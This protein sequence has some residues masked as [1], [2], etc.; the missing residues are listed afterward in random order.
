MTS[1]ATGDGDGWITLAD[2]THRW[3]RY[4]AAGL[5]LHAPA[6]DGGRCVLLQHRAAWSH[7][8]DTWGLPGGAADSGEGPVAAALREFGEEVAGDLG[9]VEVTG[10]Y[11]AGDR[12]WHYDSVLA[13]APEAAEFAPGN[14]E[15]EAVRWV[16]LDEVPSLPLLPAFA[17]AWPLLRS[18]L[19]ARLVLVVEAG[20]VLEQAGEAATPERT[21]ALRDALSGL[22]RGGLPAGDLPP[23]LG[24]PPLHTWFPRVRLVTPVPV[25]PAP[26][27]AVVAD[28][29]GA[30]AGPEG[31]SAVLTVTAA[32]GPRTVPPAWLL[33]RAGAAAPVPG[34]DRQVAL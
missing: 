26:G 23:G 22:V 34:S 7:Q 8:G 4:G 29:T 10:V 3:G 15:S 27:V 11:R 9:A 5:L 14:A 33:E 25:A 17:D 20:P 6:P 30:G 32:G 31:R 19:A 28:R 18:A 21:S 13:A 24:L 1:G 16:P 12:V 2:G